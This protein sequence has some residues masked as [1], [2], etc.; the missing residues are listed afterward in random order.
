VTRRLRSV[1]PI[2]LRSELVQVESSACSTLLEETILSD[3]LRVPPSSPTIR[4]MRQ[5]FWAL[6]LS[7]VVTLQVSVIQADEAL[8]ASGL[9]YKIQNFINALAKYTDT[10]CIPGLGQQGVTFLLLSKEPIFS[11]EASKKAWLVV[12]VGAVGKVMNMHHSIKASEVYVS[13]MG[14]MKN[15]QGFKYPVDLSPKDFNN[16]PPRSSWK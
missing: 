9:C 15:R 13:D 11:G 12:T 3:L 6:V 8:E 16:K 14:L 1:P 2:S 10:L 7:S 4:A 5:A